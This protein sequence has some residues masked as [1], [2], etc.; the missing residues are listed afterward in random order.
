MFSMINSRSPTPIYVQIAEQ[1]RRAVASGE[2]APGETLP[3]V[4]AL[5][6]RLR[7]NPATIS[8]AFREL[9]REGLA[10]SD[11]EG[12]GAIVRISL[13]P[14]AASGA[15]R[16]AQ[17]ARLGRT[18]ADRV[19][20]LSR[21]A[22]GSVIESRFHVLRLLGAGS[23]GAVYLAHDRELDEEVALK[24]LPPL[25]TGDDTSARRFLNEIRVARRISHR[26]VVRTHDVGRWSGGLFLTMEYVS[27]RTLREVLDTRGPLPEPEVVALGLQLAEA[28]AVAHEQGVIHRD[29]KPQNLLLDDAGV[30]KV[31]DFG[32]AVMQGTS[33]QLTEAG[34]VVGTPAYM[35]PE[36]L[37]GEP[38]SPAAD[39]YAAG[40]VLY[41]CLSG[42]LPVS[43]DTPM[44]LVAQIVTH[45]P[46]PL[47][48]VAPRVS[49]ALAD[50]V[51]RLLQPEATRRPTSAAGLVE[52]L[53]RGLDRIPGES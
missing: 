27:G 13:T 5:A 19:E 49:P 22:P 15:K 43:A 3:T 40:V 42:R 46:V 33:G 21:L 37:L 20:A 4:R 51:M 6:A 23:M 32:I 31:L 29:V 9:V 30:L 28:L 25:A 44:S 38:L 34:L 12:T 11:G 45:G 41:E 14:D 17:A 1:V 18:R 7:V 24:V 53:R 52:A 10:E 48:E 8:H 26:N 16:A 35:S 36:Q 50:T 47:L 2:V 39:L